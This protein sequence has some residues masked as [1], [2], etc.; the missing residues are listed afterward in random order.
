M[1]KRVKK[2]TSS[3]VNKPISTIGDYEFNVI[4]TNKKEL[5]E[6]YNRCLEEL[7]ELKEREGFDKI[8]FESHQILVRNIVY[9]RNVLKDITKIINKG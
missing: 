2:G 6:F 4:I 5:L 7:E 9:K 8:S 3:K 1:K